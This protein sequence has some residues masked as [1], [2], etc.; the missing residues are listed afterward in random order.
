[1]TDSTAAQSDIFEPAGNSVRKE[2]ISAE[3]PDLRRPQRQSYHL[4][5]SRGCEFLQMF[6][7]A[8]LHVPI[9][10]NCLDNS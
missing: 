9:F 3:Q 8:T 1:M 7:I 6:S 5:K 2:A 4:C 10:G